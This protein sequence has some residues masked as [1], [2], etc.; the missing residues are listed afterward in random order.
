MAFINFKRL[1]RAVFLGTA[2]LLTHFTFASASLAEAERAIIARD[3]S[4]ALAYAEAAI[5]TSPARARVLAA[6]AYLELGQLDKAI[7]LSKQATDLAPRSR[8]AY[9]IR[10]V[11]L[12]RGG[13]GI[14]A[15]IFARRALD[16]SQTT[17]ERTQA[18][19][20]LRDI[21][22]VRNW[23]VTGGIG[24]APST[25]ITR[26][27]TA[28]TVDGIFGTGNLSGIEV[29]SGTGLRLHAGIRRDFN[30][31]A[32]TKLSFYIGG[33]Q[34]SYRDPGLTSGLA[35]V[36]SN[37]S[38][39]AG[40]RTRYF[41]GVQRTRQIYLAETLA[42]TN[43]FMFGGEWRTRNALNQLK[44]SYEERARADFAVNDSYN[45]ALT[46][47]QTRALN[48]RSSI[49]WG[50]AAN[51]RV[52]KSPGVDHLGVQI[53]ASYKRLFQNG[54]SLEPGLR[55][56]RSIWNEQ[57]PLFLEPRADWS[58]SISLEIL[59]TNRSIWGFTPVI[60]LSSNEVRSNI[61]IYSYQ[62][63]DMYIGFRNT[64]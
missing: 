49:K 33:N 62:S 24:F 4:Q 63:N 1:T 50:L 60:T 54:W 46:F 42:H 10:S 15:E 17:A 38:W 55:I 48:Q 27:T 37:L 14:K 25:N 39:S 35:W 51:E 59:N 21:H 36:G 9:L 22:S 6:R 53:H 19:Q 44:F 5:D 64:F 26:A 11:A 57:E 3:W 34:T 47:N 30:F 2:F 12:F 29:K 31:T 56:G 20:V 32:G 8:G 13:Q 41:V 28:R 7:D 61:S 16:L 52:S 45:H 18:R 43:Q 40:Q 58:T 23:F